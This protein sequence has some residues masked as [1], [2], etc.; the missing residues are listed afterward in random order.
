MRLTRV[1]ALTC[2]QLGRNL[3]L[4]IVMAN[5]SEFT[6]ELVSWISTTY[7]VKDR[8]KDKEADGIQGDSIYTAGSLET[9][10]LSPLT[11]SRIAASTVRELSAKIVLLVSV[12]AICTLLIAFYDSHIQDDFNGSFI[13]LPGLSKLYAEPNANQT[14]LK[15]TVAQFEAGYKQNGHDIVYLRL[16]DTVLIDSMHQSPFDNMKSWEFNALAYDNSENSRTLDLALANDLTPTECLLTKH[17]SIHTWAA[18]LSSDGGCDSTLLLDNRPFW[19][20]TG[21]KLGWFTLAL[22]LITIIAILIF[23]FDSIMAFVLPLAHAAQSMICMAQLLDPNW[24][25]PKIIRED[26]ATDD[27]GCDD[28]PQDEEPPGGWC[29]TLMLSL[30]AREQYLGDSIETLHDALLVIE[31]RFRVPMLQCRRAIKASQLV[32]VNSRS[33]FDSAVLLAKKV[34]SDELVMSDTIELQ[35]EVTQLLPEEY[36]S[37]GKKVVECVVIAEQA[38]GCLATEMKVEAA[39]TSKGELKLGGARRA[40]ISACA[41]VLEAGQ[42]LRPS[43]ESNYDKFKKTLPNARELEQVVQRLRG[44]AGEGVRD[45]VDINSIMKIAGLHEEEVQ[46]LKLVLASLEH[47]VGDNAVQTLLQNPDFADLGKL[48][49][50]MP[51]EVTLKH[52]LSHVFQHFQGTAKNQFVKFVVGKLEKEGLSPTAVQWMASAVSDMEGIPS[53]VQLNE[54]V[55]QLLESLAADT[56]HPV[57]KL[58]LTSLQ[59]NDSL[60]V[61]EH[62]VEMLLEAVL[63]VHDRNEGSPQLKMALAKVIADTKE[64]VELDKILS[65]LQDAISKAGE[66]HQSEQLLV[67]ITAALQASKG[68]QLRGKFEAFSRVVEAVGHKVALPAKHAPD[69]P[70]GERGMVVDAL[71]EILKISLNSGTFSWRD[72]FDHE[73]IA[74]LVRKYTDVADPDLLVAKPDQ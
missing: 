3:Q 34:D 8:S 22:G 25:D 36:N 54:L 41:R 47:V 13:T 37:Q 71:L 35:Q 39:F 62:A 33:M 4:S 46:A 65:A 73:S 69:P 67:A 7:C 16:G 10:K 24:K 26:E 44:A 20:S 32:L 63:W 17:G 70:N 51:D 72:A 68:S 43:D 53:G 74:S 66:D 27:N 11:L 52:Q 58:A 49:T 40:L 12:T 31:R 30:R 61:D 29:E 56:S 19:Q 23:S 55:V 14:L 45:I 42:M 64:D 57:V 60:L 1:I 9:L 15:H 59:Q 50:L 28:S 21:L 2:G 5:F 6:V 48:E 18:T 38:L